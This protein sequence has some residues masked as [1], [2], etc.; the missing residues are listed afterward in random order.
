MEDNVAQTYVSDLGI[1]IQKYAEESDKKFND[2]LQKYLTEDEPVQQQTQEEL[3]PE[4]EFIEQPLS[5]EEIQKRSELLNYFKVAQQHFPNDWRALGIS[6]EIIMEADI[7]KLELIKADYQFRR[8][9]SSSFE[10]I[11][12]LANKAILV[13][14]G[15][16]SSFGLELGGLSKRLET[17]EDY[18]SA[19]K[20]V[21][22]DKGNKLRLSPISR[23]CMVVAVTA[24]QVHTDN[25]VNK[26]IE[27]NYKDI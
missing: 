10:A 4:P 11:V 17:N 14:E 26:D 20:A 6:E 22:H 15:M 19:L 13:A 8:D 18:N 12:G 1:D 25:T 3:E 2:E 21:I 7:E 24:Y 27:E 16:S 23:L 9:C 5:I